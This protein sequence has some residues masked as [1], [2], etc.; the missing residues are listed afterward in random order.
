M[1]KDLAWLFGF[2]LRGTFRK[3]SSWMLYLGLPVVGVLTSVLLYS[4]TQSPPLRVAIVN[5]D[6]AAR[7]AAD[8]AAYVGGLREVQ[9][10]ELGREEAKKKSPPAAWTW[11]SCWS[12]AFRPPPPRAIRRESPWNRSRERR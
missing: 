7:I 11:R 10:Q 1:I 2:M 3:R 12:L 8:T 4:G 5:E 9:V 6:G